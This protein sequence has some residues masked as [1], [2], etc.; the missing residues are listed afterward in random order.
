MAPSLPCAK[1]GS[2]AI[3]LVLAACLFAAHSV[4]DESALWEKVKSGQHVVLMRHALA[5]GF[6]D[7][8]NFKVDD[9]STQRNLS[10]TG[11]KQAQAIG[12]RFKSAGINKAEV[13]SSQW[14][15]CLE[16]ARLLGLGEVQALPIINSFFE[17]RSLEGDQTQALREWLLK[18]DLSKPTVLVTHQ[19]NITAI[20][21]VFP[22]PGEMVILSVESGKLE[23]AG[24]VSTSEYL[25]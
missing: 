23:L 20:S 2:Y 9:C 15:R 8:A 7:P 6:S 25:K 13:Y 3:G 19:V 16:T 22:A 10:D 21:G 18:Q 24:R 5:P 4:A 14:C 12:E 1:F 11:R 17:Q